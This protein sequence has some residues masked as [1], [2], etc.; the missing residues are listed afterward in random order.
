MSRILYDETFRDTI[1]N[2]LPPVEETQRR[3]LRLRDSKSPLRRGLEI[4]ERKGLS[5]TFGLFLLHRHFPCPR[6]AIMLEQPLQTKSGG[7]LY[8][9]APSPLSDKLPAFAPSRFMFVSRGRRTVLAPLEF[10]TDSVVVN[11]WQKAAYDGELLGDLASL[12]KA[13]KVQSL[14][15]LTVVAREHEDAT[16]I[17][18]EDTI[19]EPPHSLVRWVLPEEFDPALTI[20]TIW[21]GRRAEGCCTLMMYCELRCVKGSEDNHSTDVKCQLD[22]IGCTEALLVN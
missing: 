16:K 9:T 8:V 3:F 4:I 22:H 18:I 17:L 5:P 20:P 12:L 6:G 1:Y 19:I 15:G 2:A 21:T 13:H 14:L 7:W 11:S 10:S